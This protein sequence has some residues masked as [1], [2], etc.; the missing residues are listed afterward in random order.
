[1]SNPAVEVIVAAEE[2]VYDFLTATGLPWNLQER[3]TSVEHLWNSMEQAKTISPTSK[4]AFISA[5]L[6]QDGATTVADTIATIAGAMPTFLIVWD[7]ANLPTVLADIKRAGQVVAAGSHLNLHV[8][9]ASDPVN[10]LVD[11]R[12]ATQE[13]L[14]WPAE[15]QTMPSGALHRDGD[16]PGPAGTP[17]APGGLGRPAPSRPASTQQEPVAA[18]PTNGHHPTG[19]AGPQVE[20]VTDLP[21]AD[22][23][24]TG[25][26]TEIPAEPPAA[27]PAEAPAE[28]PA[29]IPATADSQAANTSTAQVTSPPG[30][31][32]DG[33]VPGAPSYPESADGVPLTAPQETSEADLDAALP[34]KSQHT[35]SVTSSKGGAG[36]TTS[37]LCLAGQIAASSMKAFEEG[38][39][40][41]PLKVVVVDMDIHDGQVGTA[42]GHY[43]PTAMNIR[44]APSWDEEN[45]LTNLVHSEN[46]GIDLLL[47]PTRVRAANDLTPDF[48]RQVI[49]HLQRTH[50][51]VILDTSV[52]YTDPLIA[53]VCY[54]ES[55]AIVF[56][57]TLVS[58]ALIGMARAVKEITDPIEKGGLGV[59]GGRI[60]ILVNQSVRDVGVTMD[61]VTQ[62]TLGTPIIGAI[63]LATWDVQMA[64]N[65]QD[66]HMLLRHPK[67]GKAYYKFARAVL[68]DS[69]DAASKWYLLPLLQDA[70]PPK[71]QKQT[72]RSR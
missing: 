63:P 50:D 35:I 61:E 62:G 46:M 8:F 9:R 69:G 21:V 34:S 54:K 25:L 31:V 19:P 42:L 26:P 43:A 70:A 20:P 47:A 30:T 60:G 22:P 5:E 18:S 55:S 39:T 52:R 59:D 67:L 71:A 3:A 12:D 37:A 45:I 72:A 36:K 6:Q 17:P 32:P 44:V 15:L 66:L 23:A 57:T 24:T 10:A 33:G 64:T 4:L 38:Q 7:E 51:V 1:M 11:V 49:R 14:P 68:P 40:D 29:G 48:Y 65:R 53:E 28:V 56:V 27:A 58:T 13:L 2:S 41:A 16:N